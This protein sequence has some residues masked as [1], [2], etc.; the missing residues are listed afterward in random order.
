MGHFW[1]IGQLVVCVDTN[2]LSPPQPGERFPDKG[3]TFTLMEI[4]PEQG[5]APGELGFRFEECSPRGGGWFL[6][7]H[8]RP[9]RLISN[10][11]LEELRALLPKEKRRKVFEP[12]V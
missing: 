9:A 11:A 1:R 3:E 5:F 10:R 4:D 6:S 7:R 8:F 12:A 2:W